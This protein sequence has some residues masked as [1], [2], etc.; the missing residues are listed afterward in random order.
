MALI[1]LFLQNFRS[2]T[3]TN[4][5]FQKDT[6]LIVGPNTAGK[7]NLIE[8]IFLLS[9]GKSFRSDQDMQMMQFGKNLT[10]AKG[11]TIDA[12]VGETVLEVVLTRTVTPESL[13][14]EARYQTVPNEAQI[15][16][17]KKYLVNGIPRRRIDFASHLH[18]LLFSP[19]DLEII[20]AGPSLRREFL[21][22]VLEQ[23]HSDYRRSRSI[24]A[25]AIRQ[26]NALLET[27]RETGVRPERQFTYWN[28]LLIE[29]GTL[30][31]KKR[32]MFINY[33]NEQSK[34]IMECKVVYDHSIIS[35]ERLFQYREAEVASGVTLVGPHRDDFLVFMLGDKKER[36][37]KQFGSRGQQRLA[38]LQL[39]LL[40]MSYMEQVLPQRPVLLLDDIFSELDADHINL[41]LEI[42]GKQQT[43]ITTTHKEFISKDL[44]KMDMIELNGERK[45][46]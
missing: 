13:A 41:I 27:A 32:E 36:N 45:L 37:I 11:I 42:I 1:Q 21:D 38:I 2:Y 5:T 30:I 34:N 16:M 22:S 17:R 20:I 29:N 28:Q 43:I 7:S 4:F 9:S 26:R 25:K 6:T 31:T 3:K 8:A 18:A 14:N 33:M 23:T 19:Q 44:K 15:S 12:E 35:E 40:Q 39:K 24:Y 46:I 10:R